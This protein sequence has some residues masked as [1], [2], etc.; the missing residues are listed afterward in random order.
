MNEGHH[1]FKGPDINLGRKSD[2]SMHPDIH[3]TFLTQSDNESYRGG[4]NSIYLKLSNSASWAQGT[5]YP[6][7][8]TQG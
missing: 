7:T 5:F 2:P 1:I 4:E 3:N 6:F 8:A